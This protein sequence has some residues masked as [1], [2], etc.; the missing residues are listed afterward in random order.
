VGSVMIPLMIKNGYPRGLGV[1]RNYLASFWGEHPEFREEY[2]T[3]KEMRAI[4]LQAIGDHHATLAGNVT[5]SGSLQPLLLPPSH[6][7]I[8]I[9]SP[10]NGPSGSKAAHTDRATLAKRSAELGPKD[11][12]CQ[13]VRRA[14]H[15]VVAGVEH[16]PA[17]LEPVG[18]AADVRLTRIGCAAAV[19]HV[20]I[21]RLIPEPLEFHRAAVDESGMEGDAIRGPSAQARIEVGE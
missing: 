2:D 8:T 10:P 13:G 17:R 12:R 4:K 3:G 19:E 18:G 7:M 14:Q 5:I 1:N 11:Y 21:P 6:N 9:R 15:G 16:M 20:G